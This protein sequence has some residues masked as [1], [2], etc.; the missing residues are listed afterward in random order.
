MT[1]AAPPWRVEVF[2]LCLVLYGGG[3]GS[4]EK[5]PTPQAHP[6]KPSV[7]GAPVATPADSWSFDETPPGALPEAFA[8]HAGEWNVGQDGEAPSGCCVLIQAADSPPSLF[9]LVLLAD[10]PT[11]DVDV[12]LKLRAREGRI[13]QGGGGVWRARNAQN[14]YIARYNPLEEN[15]R[16]YVVEDGK[17]SQLASADVSLDPRAWHAMR[18]R[19][20][21]DH[22]ECA[23]DGQKYLDVHDATFA[24]PGK[25]GLWTKADARTQFDDVSVSPLGSTGLAPAR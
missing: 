4:E 17:R 8:V 16:V 12:S 23:L 2:L 7:Q 22:I 21:G 6:E 14:Y 9:N 11:A 18:I 25:V 3:C 10:I 20:A 13:D 19:M 15:F 5:P 1:S 24:G